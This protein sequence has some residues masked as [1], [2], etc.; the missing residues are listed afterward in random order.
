MGNVNQNYINHIALVV[1]CSGSMSKLTNDVI[2]IVDNQVKHLAH[3]SKEMDQETRVTVYTFADKV[4][5]V[6]YDKDALRLPSVKDH[7]KMYGNTALVDGTMQSILDLEKTATLYGDHSF[8]VYVITDGEENCSKSKG[9]AL[10]SKIASLDDNWTVAAFVPNVIGKSEAKRFGFPAE[11]VAIWDTSKDGVAEVG[12]V[13]METTNNY[14]TGRS[15]GTRGYKNLFSIQDVSK[16][17]VMS[18][19]KKLHPGQYRMIDVV[20]KVKIALLVEE[21]T[22]RS[23]KL[24]EGYYQL[25]KPEK[26][27]PE[28]SIALMDKTN[29]SL[30]VGADARKLLGLPDHEVK[31]APVSWPDFEIF[32][33]SASVN[34]NL[35]AGT[36][37]LLLS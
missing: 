14:M 22:K 15:T 23:Y 32:V 12:R 28:K 6:F 30:F 24:G 7:V 29:K 27:Q 19:L 10:N 33:Q 11:N 20:D 26:I 31:V 37:L 18:Q 21:V 34:R 13:I 8:L 16:T 35:M 5:C 3:R 9:T 4:N 25:S 2:T 1:D 17:D 36:K